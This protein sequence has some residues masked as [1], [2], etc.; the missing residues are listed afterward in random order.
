VDPHGTRAVRGTVAGRTGATSRQ[1]VLTVT[2][3]KRR[4]RRGIKGGSAPAGPPVGPLLA[5]GKLA[6]GRREGSHA[7]S[8]LHRLISRAVVDALPSRRRL[9]AGGQW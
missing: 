6:E 2:V 5:S 7:R 4:L 9:K 3:G 8:F 1:L